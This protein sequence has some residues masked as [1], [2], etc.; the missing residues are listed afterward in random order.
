MRRHT[1]VG[2]SFVAPGRPEYG[3][4]MSEKPDN[5]A[6]GVQP[7]LGLKGIEAEL[8]AG[9]SVH[10]REAAM[11]VG[12]ATGQGQLPHILA[13]LR[14]A[15]PRDALE[16]RLVALS[17]AM[18]HAAVENLS[19]SRLAQPGPDGTGDRGRLA[20]VRLAEATCK[21]VE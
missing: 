4:T 5:S 3:N 11:L 15:A 13:A 18:S 9:A 16:A 20:A 17:L 10:E 14:S 21:C 19:W 6:E 8:W 2:S 7:G 12:K 1:E